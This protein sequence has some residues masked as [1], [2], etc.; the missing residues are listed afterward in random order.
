MHVKT[1]L[2]SRGSAIL[3]RRA[4]QRPRSRY[5]KCDPPTERRQRGSGS[6][7]ARQAMVRVP[8]SAHRTSTTKSTGIVRDIDLLRA[9][10]AAGLRVNVSSSRLNDA[11]LL[12]YRS[13]APRAHLLICDAGRHR[14]RQTHAHLRHACAALITTRSG[15][16]S[17][18]HRAAE[19]PAEGYR[20]SC[21]FAQIHRSD[22]STS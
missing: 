9:G 10:R 13:L 14:S 5:C 6:R 2:I 4:Q 22:F 11:P 19:R 1:E 12:I 7:G 20:R 16:S 18:S 8:W 17:A 3:K 21:F 15:A